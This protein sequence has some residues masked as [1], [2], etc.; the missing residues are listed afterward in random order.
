MAKDQVEVACDASLKQLA[1]DYIDVY[2]FIILPIPN[3][4]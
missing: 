2:L 3:S 1:T 4:Y